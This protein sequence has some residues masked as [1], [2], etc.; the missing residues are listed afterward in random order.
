ML[1]WCSSATA[2]SGSCSSSAL[3]QQRPEG[4]SL[5]RYACLY[6]LFLSIRLPASAGCCIFVSLA[7]VSFCLRLCFLW[8]VSCASSC[9]RLLLPL[10]AVSWCLLLSLPVVRCFCL[11]AGALSCAFIFP[12]L[13]PLVAAVPY[14]C[15]LQSLFVP[16]CLLLSLFFC[17]SLRF[18]ECNFLYCHSVS[19]WLCLFCRLRCYF[20]ILFSPCSLHAGPRTARSLSGL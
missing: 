16:V 1:C 12:L 9:L 19:S 18:L 10:F 20:C 13:C 2:A 6:V 15:L 4:S 3:Q 11:R 7:T 14:C 5:C 8:F 17:C